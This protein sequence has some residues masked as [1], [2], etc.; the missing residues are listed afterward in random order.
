MKKIILTISVIASITGCAAPGPN[1]LD[2]LAQ[3]S[4]QQVDN[5]S[6]EGKVFIEGGGARDELI[7]K[8]QQTIANQL[9]D[10]AAAQFRNV[11][12]K[13]YAGGV[14]VC[15]EVNGKNSYG[16][17]VGFKRFV[18]GPTAGTIEAV[19]GKYPQI[20]AVANSGLNMACH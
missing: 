18:A 12:V 5:F 10:P 17:Y 9:K 2:R 6:Q 13:D 1:P 11:N 4:Y 8:A 7:A 14:L 20:D 16:A 19:G 15:G 3:Q